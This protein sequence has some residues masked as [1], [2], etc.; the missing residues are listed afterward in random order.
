MKKILFSF[1]FLAIS[2]AVFAG[3]FVAKAVYTNKVSALVSA[4]NKMYVQHVGGAMIC[5][6]KAHKQV[7]IYAP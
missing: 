4:N 5:P 2:S 7:W 3:D 6:H 1:A